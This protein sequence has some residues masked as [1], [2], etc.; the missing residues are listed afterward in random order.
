MKIISLSKKFGSTLGQRS[1]A[2][3]LREEVM[4]LDHPLQLDFS[5]VKIISY[6]FAEEFFGKLACQFGE[7]IFKQ[8][9]LV[10]NVRPES[11]SVI[12]AAIR[13]QPKNDVA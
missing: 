11:Q 1:R 3:E 9:I 12:H 7:S 2:A 6:T 10:K 8:R 13:C 4:N 5:G